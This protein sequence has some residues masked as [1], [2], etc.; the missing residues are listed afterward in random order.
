MSALPIA[1]FEDDRHIGS[2][3]EVTPVSIRANLPLASKTEGLVLHGNYFGAGEVGEFVCVEC[4]KTAVLGRINQVKLPEKDRL[5]V[6]PQ[7]GKRPPSHPIGTIQ[8]AM[9]Y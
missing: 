9:Q 1:P 4:G 8:A 3:I 6:E 2:V 5:T 7:L